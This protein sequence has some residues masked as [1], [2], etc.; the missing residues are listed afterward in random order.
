MTG[1]GVGIGLG[2]GLAM[3]QPLIGL[4]GGLIAGFAVGWL[5]RTRIEPEPPPA[6]DG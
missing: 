1:A 3:N 6:P 5:L 2:M 4:A